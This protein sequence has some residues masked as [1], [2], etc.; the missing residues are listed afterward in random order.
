MNSDNT[1][2]LLE[3]GQIVGPVFTAVAA[4]AACTAVYLT[5]RES[6]LS[7][8][9]VLRIQAIVSPQTGFYGATIINAGD[10]VA[11][12]VNF[13]VADSETVIAGPVLNGFLR[14][15]ES[16]DVFAAQP[17]TD[18]SDRQAVVGYV[19]GRD[20]FGFPHDWTTDLG[21][22][23]NYKRRWRSGFR[24][25]PAY[26]EIISRLRGWFP[27][28]PGPEKLTQIPVSSQTRLSDASR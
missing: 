25:E 23:V 18:P 7:H 1:S 13:A 21:H 6:R 19:T 5:L 10:G 24:K 16:V 9:P 12:G 14:P 2:T 26:G 3:V 20:R 27:D 28:H 11:S 15:G 8:Q 17:P 4:L 22:C